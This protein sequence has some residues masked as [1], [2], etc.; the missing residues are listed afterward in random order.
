M[1]VGVLFIIATG[2]FVVG[3][4]IYAPVL[5]SADVLRIADPARVTAMAGLLVELTALLAIPLTA[6]FL[7]PVLKRHGEG[8]ALAYVGLRTIEALLLILGTVAHLALLGLSQEY[9]G[10]RTFQAYDWETMTAL[11]RILREGG[12]VLSIGVVFPIGSLLLNTML[13]R[14]RLVPRAL[15]G[16]GLFGAALL[17]VGSVLDLSGAFAGAPRWAIEGALPAPIAIQEMAFAGWLIGRGFS[18]QGRNP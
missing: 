3:G 13:Y 17:L 6:I 9:L 4:A 5:G 18:N 14:T 16:W 1:I 10:Q 15:S 11:I 7:F 8:P 12:F 2:F